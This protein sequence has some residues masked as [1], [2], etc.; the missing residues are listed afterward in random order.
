MCSNKL[1][2]LKVLIPPVFLALVALGC[3]EPGAGPRAMTVN[4]AAWQHSV[5]QYVWDEGNGDPNVLRDTNLPT[6]Q[7]G[8]ALI[9]GPEIER[10]NDADGL[11]LGQRVIDGHRWFIFLVGLIQEGSLEDVRLVGLLW[12]PVGVTW[13]VGARDVQMVRRYQATQPPRAFSVFPAEGDQFD[14]A[15]QGC[16]AVVAHLHSGAI[17]QLDLK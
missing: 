7:R 17:W 13:R 12:T 16:Q 8:F 6:S 14:L 5:E 1:Q 4:L 10:S 3:A 2:P 9:G 15:I 11:L